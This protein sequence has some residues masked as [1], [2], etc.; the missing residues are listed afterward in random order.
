MNDN[1]KQKF[2]QLIQRPGCVYYVENYP[3]PNRFL[4]F[5]SQEDLNSYLEDSNNDFRTHN[6]DVDFKNKDV[7]FETAHS[8]NRNR[9]S[10]SF[11]DFVK[12]VKILKSRA[13]NP[14]NMH[15]YLGNPPESFGEWA[16]YDKDEV[17]HSINTHDSVFDV[18]NNISDE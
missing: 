10:P 5:K 9:V 8:S 18:L 16:R 15:N 12:I 7:T 2:I 14:E 3:Y 11:D 1:R 17:E 4:R 6:I 13:V